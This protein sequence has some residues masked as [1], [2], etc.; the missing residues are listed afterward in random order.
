MVFLEILRA[1]F[2]ALFFTM[3]LPNPRRYTFSFSP[4]E[5]NEQ[6][7]C[8]IF[9]R[10]T[11]N[12]HYLTTLKNSGV[13][14]TSCGIDTYS[15]I[16]YYTGFDIHQWISENVDWKNDFE[17]HMRSVVEKQNLESYLIW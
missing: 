4:N 1:V 7:R 10:S 17:P 11:E 9:V 13:W 6:Y 15:Q 14:Q 8:M 2:C 3:K 16:K 5:E 12:N